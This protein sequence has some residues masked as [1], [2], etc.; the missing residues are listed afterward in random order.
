M[1]MGL[2]LIC[3]L[4]FIFSFGCGSNQN[5]TTGEENT[6]D[7]SNDAKTLKVAMLMSG[8]ISDGGYNASAYQ[9]LMDSKKELG[10]EVAYSES[11]PLAE[12]EAAFRDYAMQGYDI[13]IGHGF[14]FQDGALKVAKEFPD[15]KFLVVSGNQ[16]QEPNMA[17]INLKTEET[18]YLMGA[19]AGMMTKSNKIGAVG[20]APVPPIVAPIEAFKQG[21]RLVNPEVEILDSYIGSWDDVDKAKET[22]IAMINKG[23]DIV[24]PIASMAGVGVIKGAQEKGAYALGYSA[25]QNDI[26]PGTVLSSGILSIP[27]A[28]R[29]TLKDIKD[30]KFKA[31]VIN[32]GLKDG[33]LKIA[34]YHEA[35]KLVPKDVQDKMEQIEQDII[36]GAIQVEFIDQQ[37]SN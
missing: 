16:G 4:L 3:C 10:I 34:P 33:V 32:Y 26:A 15:V 6:A 5:S 11:V 13:V 28:I 18:G 1:T 17:S 8:P 29:L 19:L 27:D 31:G 37:T 2:V 12:Y 21:A 20:G 14:E 35:E 22:A 30:G 7:T 25:D 24:M 36:N 23:A 9:G